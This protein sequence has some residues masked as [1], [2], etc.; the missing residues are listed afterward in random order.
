M[1]AEFIPKPSSG[2]SPTTAPM[3]LGLL[4][5][6]LVDHIATVD[7]SILAKIPSEPGGSFPV[8]LLTFSFYKLFFSLVFV[9]HLSYSCGIYCS[10][11]T[12]VLKGIHL[13]LKSIKSTKM[14]T[15]KFYISLKRTKVQ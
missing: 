1:G 14:F 4:L 15:K 2:E 9:L 5:T 13:V 6:A 10:G 12:N 7:S 3:I 8:Y 11:F